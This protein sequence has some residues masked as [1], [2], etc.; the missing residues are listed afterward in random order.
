MQVWVDHVDVPGADAL[1]V[2]LLAGACSF[3]FAFHLNKGVTS[4]SALCQVHGDV[5]FSNSEIGEELSDLWNCHLERETSEF[6]TL[7]LVLFC[8]EI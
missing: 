7:V 8:H 4:W 2:Q 1:A 5:T 3:I 6:E